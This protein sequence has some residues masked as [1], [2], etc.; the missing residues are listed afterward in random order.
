M[1]IIGYK[2]FNNDMT[3]RHGKK[4]QVNGIYISNGEI[5]FG[6]E[7]MH[8]FHLCENMEDTFRYFAAKEEEVKICLV[9]G[10][11]K[12][13]KSEDDYNSYYGM[14]SVEQLEILSILTRDEVISYGLNLCAERVKRFITTFKLTDFEIH[15][16]I[17][18]FCNDDSVLKYISYYQLNDKNV[19]IENKIKT[20]NSI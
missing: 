9:R 14:Y 3:N 17:N 10:S 11:G 4:F 6:N 20:I 19:F 15:L 13:V 7:S 1:E 18:K 8:G 2:C 5:Q 16:F 12:I